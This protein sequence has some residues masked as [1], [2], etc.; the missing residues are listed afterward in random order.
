MEISKDLVRKM[1]ELSRVKL[2]EAELA[3][4]EKEF[5]ELFGHFSSIEKIGAGGE[6]LFYVTGVQGSLRPDEPRPKARGDADA[7][8]ENFAQ[9]DG[10]LMV[11]PKSLD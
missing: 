11:A 3:R 10:R 8:V 1:G 9:K 7:I 5:A 6:R 2:S 4:L